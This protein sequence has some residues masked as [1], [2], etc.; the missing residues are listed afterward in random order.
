MS[1]SRLEQMRSQFQQNLQI[2]SGLPRPTRIPGPTSA[3]AKT[4]AT[5]KQTPPSL[6]ANGH[7]LTAAASPASPTSRAN[8][9]GKLQNGSAHKDVSGIRNGQHNGTP[10]PL[11]NG[12]SQARTPV[13]NGMRSQVTSTD[14]T[15]PP[16]VKGGVLMTMTTT[17]LRQLS[18]GHQNSCGSPK[19]TAKPI[20]SPPV[21]TMTP[22]ARTSVMP[23]NRAIATKPTAKPV[24]A[25]PP[26]K[27]V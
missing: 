22:V 20:S 2:R 12:T 4:T 26:K 10:R 1:A 14:Q 17:Q 8:F 16:V 5:A 21:R 13:S 24:S 11:T 23:S 9:N 27:P 6:R 15:L 18:N 3:A 19:P 7:G 25:D